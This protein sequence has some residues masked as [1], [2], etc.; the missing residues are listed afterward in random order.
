MKPMVTGL[1]GLAL[2]GMLIAAPADKAKADGGAVAVGVGAYLVVDY[3]VG[4]ECDM[5]VWPFNIVK[6]V[7]Y[8][9]KGRRVCKVYRRK[10]RY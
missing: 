4:R 9:I 3:L 1:A 5:H 10:Y 6:K 2:A 7:V 8:K